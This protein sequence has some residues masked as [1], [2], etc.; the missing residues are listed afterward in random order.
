MRQQADVTLLRKAENYTKLY[1][2]FAAISWLIV[3][4]N[5]IVATENDS[6]NLNSKAVSNR[7][8]EAVLL[9]P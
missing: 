3:V 2:T 1:H 7:P 9:Q 8:K 5:E 4:G 6:F